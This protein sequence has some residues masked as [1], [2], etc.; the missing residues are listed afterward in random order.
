MY[1]GIASYRVHIENVNG[2]YYGVN[3]TICTPTAAEEA[4]KDGKLSDLNPVYSPAIWYAN[5]FAG[6]TADMLQE[7]GTYQLRGY[8]FNPVDQLLIDGTAVEVN[9]DDL[10]WSYNV[11]LQPGVNNVPVV[12]VKDG[13]N[14]PAPSQKILYETEGPKLVL[15]LP[16][17]KDGK[18]Y[19]DDADFLLR[20]TVTT[21][22]DD[23]QVYV[24]DTHIFGANNFG[25]SYGEETTT[26]EFS[27]PLALKPGE[28]YFTVIA[29]NYL[30]LSTEIPI[31]LVYGVEP[32]TCTH[33]HTTTTMVPAT[34]TEP[35]SE[36]IVCDDCGETISVKELP[37][38]GPVSYT[39]LT[40]PTTSRV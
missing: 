39:H 15:E 24:N 22:L 37:A 7:D 36:T 38:L 40:L 21:R 32:P 6:V 2:D 9:A 8:L 27:Y 17:E 29:Y 23:A 31:I 3:G 13:K 1:D 18:Y 25:H 14:Y 4:L 35:G 12:A 11:K 26:R 16:E 19:V 10:T 34:C 33:E 20:G 30:G 5:G 28:N